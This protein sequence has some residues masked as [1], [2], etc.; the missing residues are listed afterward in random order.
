MTKRIE[1]SDTL[2]HWLEAHAKKNETIEKTAEDNFRDIC[3][4]ALSTLPLDEYAA[5]LKKYARLKYPD[6]IRMFERILMVTSHPDVVSREKGEQAF[7]LR[8]FLVGYPC[9]T[10]EVRP[11]LFDVAGF[12]LQRSFVDWSEEIDDWSVP[13]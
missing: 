11:E 7:V 2:R 8:K 10:I 1:M 3:I 12:I 4:H 9:T 13:C 6:M 5:V